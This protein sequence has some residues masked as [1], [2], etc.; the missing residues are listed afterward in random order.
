VSGEGGGGSQRLAF[1]LAFLFRTIAEKIDASWFAS[2]SNF[3]SGMTFELAAD[4]ESDRDPGFFGFAAGDTHLGNEVPVAG[5]CVG[6]LEIER[7]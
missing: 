5:G 6:F 3:A 1:M 2:S 7:G 4:D